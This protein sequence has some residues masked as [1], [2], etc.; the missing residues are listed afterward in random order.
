VLSGVGANVDKCSFIRVNRAHNITK[1]KEYGFFVSTIIENVVVNA[2]TEIALILD[3][4]DFRDEIDALAAVAR[5]DRSCLP[6][7]E[8]G[9]LK[10][11]AIGEKKVKQNGDRRCQRSNSKFQQFHR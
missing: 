9:T 1:Q 7:T 11:V 3:T 4:I 8:I 10:A 6:E 2:I 5:G